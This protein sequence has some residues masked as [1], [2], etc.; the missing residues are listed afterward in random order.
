MKSSTTKSIFAM[1][2]ACTIWGLSGIYYDQ[3]SHIPPAEVLAHR[4]LWAMIFFSLVLLSQR[5]VPI[6]IKNLLVGPNFLL[7][8]MSALMIAVNWFA[9]I[10]AVQTSQAIQASFGY[11]IFPLVAILLGYFFKGERFSKMQTIAIFLATVSVILLGFA[12]QLVPM[13]ALVIALSFGAYGLIKGFI[14]LGSIESVTIETILLTPFAL[15]FI[16][17]SVYIKTQSNYEFINRDFFLLMASGVITGGPLILFSFATKN[18]A[19][20]T[21]GVLQYINPTLQFMVAV[22]ILFE[23]FN[24]LHACALLS[25]WIGIAIYSLESLRSESTR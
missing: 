24:F 22:V 10:F 23:P 5:R 19:Y 20:A 9:F 16:L 7:L 8:G 12:L 1:C 21:V 15:S 2:F 3:L 4:S 17:Y 11:Y 13:L 25:I 14:K 6:L 18:L